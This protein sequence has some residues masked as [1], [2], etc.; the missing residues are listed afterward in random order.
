M[1]NQLPQEWRTRL[2]EEMAFVRK[3]GFYL[4]DPNTLQSAPKSLSVLLILDET[5]RG[6]IAEFAQK[7]IPSSLKEK[8]YLQ[9]PEGYHIS[10]QWSKEFS[11]IEISD[12]VLDVEEY[13]RKI[14]NFSITMI[15]L[16]LSDNNFQLVGGT[17]KLIRSVR[18]DLSALY[19]KHQAKPKLAAN[20][21]TTWISVARILHQFSGMEIEEAA[22]KTI[23][24]KF[25]D[26]SFSTVIL[27]LNDA[28]YSKQNSEILA[29]I[30]L[31]NI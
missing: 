23:I 25:P 22:N 2:N 19:E 6:K 16:Y 20:N 15:G 28:V 24:Q 17:N 4:F 7:A 14:G 30:K 5:W 8:I 31:I 13:F 26:V 29:Q 12:L 9:P 11:R 10:L 1:F 21:G 18:N 3:N 27:T